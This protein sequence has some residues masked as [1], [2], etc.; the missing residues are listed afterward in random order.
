MD[1]TIKKM[2]SNAA[3]ICYEALE[4]RQCLLKAIPKAFE[5]LRLKTTL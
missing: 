5:A 1:G 2:L 3:K 4:E